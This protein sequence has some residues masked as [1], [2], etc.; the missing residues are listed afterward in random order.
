MIDTA[1]KNYDECHSNCKHIVR[2]CKAMSIKDVAKHYGIAE[3]TVRKKYLNGTFPMFKILNR[4]RGF[5]CWI[6]IAI[7]N[8][9]LIKENLGDQ[10]PQEFSTDK[11]LREVSL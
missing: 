5:S 7:R 4:V 11:T 10:N 1:H 3:I 8:P 2:E 6:S 9:E